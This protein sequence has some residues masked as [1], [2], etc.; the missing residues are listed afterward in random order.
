MQK[1]GR[2]LFSLL[3][4][5]LAIEMVLAPIALFHFHKSGVYGAFANILAIPLTTFFI[6]PLQI[7]ALLADFVRAGDPF[8]WLAGQGIFAIRWLAYAVSGIPGSVLVVPS[9]PGWA[10][11]AMIAGLIW[12]AIMQGRSALAGLVVTALGFAVM[13]M[14]PR[15]DMLLTGDGRH[16]AVVDENGA[17]IL[18]RSG[19]G[20][21]ALSMLAENAAVTSEPQP[22]E[23]LP[24]AECNPD[25][26]VFAI[27]RQGRDWAVLATRSRYM[28]PAMEMAAACRRVDI[29][30]SDRFLPYSC[31]PRWLKADRRLLEQSGGLAFYLGTNRVRSVAEET[32]HQPWS[33]LGLA[34]R[35]A[36]PKPKP[37]DQ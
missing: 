1:A 30:I 31:Q 36:P 10:F 24:N 19:A 27:N 22:L 13:V 4:T 32:G 25:I 37:V 5:G 35:K 2:F 8:W 3:L 21:Y 15:P 7:L 28:V 29:V 18:L 26:C 16:L 11:G 34:Q 33:R 12:A 23:T 14:A 20:D 6:M 17:L 9:I